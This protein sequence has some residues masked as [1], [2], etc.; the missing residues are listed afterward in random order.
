MRHALRYQL[1]LPLLL[2]VL[3]SSRALAQTPP[4]PDKVLDQLVQRFQ[5]HDVCRDSPACSPDMANGLDAGGKAV[6]RSYQQDAPR[7]HEAVQRALSAGTEFPYPLWN[8]LTLAG[9][10][11]SPMLEAVALRAKTGPPSESDVLVDQLLSL[12]VAHAPLQNGWIRVLLADPPARR[13]DLRN[14]RK[15]FD[16]ALE[17]HALPADLLAAVL[18]RYPDLLAHHGVSVDYPELVPAV[19]QLVRSSQVRRGDLLQ[20]LATQ[21]RTDPTCLSALQELPREERL[22][23]LAYASNGS[24]EH[25]VLFLQ[26][27]GSADQAAFN[28][29]VMTESPRTR[30]LVDLSDLDPATPGV[31]AGMRAV[32]TGQGPFR[33]DV[34]GFDDFE[35][36]NQG[37]R[38]KDAWIGWLLDEWNAERIPRGHA[39]TSRARPN[40]DSI[41]R[42]DPFELLMALR[43]NTS[44]HFEALAAPD[45]DGQRARLLDEWC[46]RLTARDSIDGPLS[47]LATYGPQAFRAGIECAASHRGQ[48]GWIAP[49]ARALEAAPDDL[50]HDIDTFRSLCTGPWT[51]VDRETLALAIA[52]RNEAGRVLAS[53][54]RYTGIA[55]TAGRAQ[56][57]DA[58]S[59]AFQGLIRLSPTLLAEGDISY[60][61]V[62]AADLVRAGLLAS[63]AQP[64]SRPRGSDDVSQEI[65]EAAGRVTAPPAVRPILESTRDRAKEGVRRWAFS[66]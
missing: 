16:Q 47:K 10:V 18:H 24:T 27:L 37:I 11:D 51:P 29:A 61:F 59:E 13:A 30:I 8:L 63:G 48:A 57:I 25:L 54:L 35:D 50:I 34:R 66:I 36:P 62:I 23:V 14:Q 40:P 33:V 46:V 53:L 4:G 15:L 65:D 64:A 32:L 56:R 55:G 28:R 20:V 6:L 19:V 41:D 17:Q 38:A 26:A 39:G 3:L 58:L 49:I 31:A 9:V 5:P 52:Q 12:L 1:V 45:D 2:P 7:L 44:A 43:V 42:T 22:R 60:A 21:L